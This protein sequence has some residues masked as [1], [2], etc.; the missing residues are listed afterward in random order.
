MHMQH[1]CFCINEVTRLIGSLTWATKLALL[2][3]RD[4][5]PVASRVHYLQR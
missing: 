2:R 3:N 4:A 5:L 1:S